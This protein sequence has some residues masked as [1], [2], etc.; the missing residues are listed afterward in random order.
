MG[1]SRHSRLAFMRKVERAETG[2][3]KAC[4]RVGQAR[5][6]Q[7][8]VLSSSSRA[9]VA[10]LASGA[11]M[12][13][14]ATEMA[15]CAPKTPKSIA[16]SCYLPPGSITMG[17]QTVPID[18]CIYTSEGKKAFVQFTASN[19]GGAGS[20]GSTTV[21]L[22]LDTSSASTGSFT[23]AS[24]P[25]PEP[26]Q[27][28]PYGT[29]YTEDS[30]DARTA[31][32]AASATSG[33]AY[34]FVVQLHGSVQD[35]LAFPGE[36]GVVVVAAGT[37][38][39]FDPGALG[40][41]HLT[42][43]NVVLSTN[44]TGGSDGTLSGTL[45][46]GVS[47][48]SDDPVCSDTGPGGASCIGNFNGCDPAK[49]NA[50]CEAAC[51][52]QVCAQQNASGQFECCSL[53]GAVCQEDGDCCGGHCVHQFCMNA[54]EAQANQSACAGTGG[55]GG[56]CSALIHGTCQSQ[57]DCCADPNIDFPPTQTG[58]CSQISSTAVKSTDPCIPLDCVNHVCC[59]TDAY[60]CNADAD[61]CSPLHC[62]NGFC[63]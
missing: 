45:V 30:T 33:K 14:G 46:A 2:D 7:G 38:W 48:H 20:T 41:L 13:C 9:V 34:V 50:D 60:H 42:L 63:G 37:T 4:E 1:I 8:G 28:K 11:L 62:S 24:W 6:A 39:A 29:V 23:V 15:G 52:D 27:I 44:Q 18:S 57:A 16:F 5:H 49:Q 26:D 35:R 61:C 58:V 25:F 40:Q 36:S 32:D 53:D 19:Y 47:V 17:T 10:A 51:K 12:L 3:W 43:G 55:T 54:E 21:T 31:F 59:R 56:A 22:A